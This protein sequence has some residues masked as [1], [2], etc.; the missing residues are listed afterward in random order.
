MKIDEFIKLDGIYDQIK[1]MLDA[2]YRS[3]GV[4]TNTELF[5]SNYSK[6]DDFANIKD[7][8][9]WFNFVFTFTQLGFR[10]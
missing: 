2:A 4:I 3:H 8:T 5:C 10:L 7:P 1:M 6:H 9:D